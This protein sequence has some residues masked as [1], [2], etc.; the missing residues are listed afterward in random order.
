[1]HGRFARYSYTGDANELA[2]MAEE[3]MLPIFEAT[4]G[5]KAYSLAESD[6]EVIS[7][8]AWESAEAAEAASSA[9]AAWIAD[10]IADRIQLKEVRIGEIMLATALGVSA[11]AGATA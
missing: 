10:N 2:R 4:P 9:A 7:Y 1:M 8:S 5:F 3:G 11:K 6:G